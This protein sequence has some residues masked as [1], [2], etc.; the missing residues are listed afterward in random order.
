MMIERPAVLALIAALTS[1]A[2][3]A[4]AETASAPPDY[5]AALGYTVRTFSTDFTLATV[6]LANSGKPGFSWYPWNLFEQRANTG[7]IRLN[8]DGS[9]T[10]AGDTTGPNAELMT[11]TQ[12]HNNDGFVGT[13]FGGGAYI[14]ATLKFN[15]DDVARVRFRGWPSFWALSLEGL[16]GSI[17]QYANQWP[18]QA[19]GYEQ[20]IETD[21]F[22]Y[23]FFPHSGSA[24]AYGASLHLWYGVPRIT[25]WRE[26]CQ[27]AGT[28]G[29]IMTPAETDF[30]QYHRYGF[31]WVPAT[32]T[33]L[34]YA[35]FYF[36]GNPMG[37]DQ[38]WAQFAKE[39][40]PPD[41][42]PWAFGVIDQRHL[43]LILGTGVGEPMTVKSVDVWQGSAQQNLHN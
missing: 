35:R 40:P 27:H 21:F 29:K 20:N 34:G 15:P 28:G 30:T 24:N 17:Y 3:L 9:V 4:G 41:R 42:K 39:P 33:T 26:L 36:D 1:G 16:K 13:A 38:Q 25:C 2:T 10:L 43:M 23:L 32:A 8:A 5:V 14:E 11:A 31:L 22:E 18:G 6:D 37:P 12:A 19:L 7:A